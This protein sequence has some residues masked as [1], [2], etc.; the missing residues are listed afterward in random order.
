MV[1]VILRVKL[2]CKVMYEKNRFGNTDV[3]VNSDVNDVH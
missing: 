1:E 2:I 3:C